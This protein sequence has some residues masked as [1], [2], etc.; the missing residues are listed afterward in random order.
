[1]DRTEILVVAASAVLVALILWFFFGAGERAGDRADA[2]S[3]RDAAPG[4]GPAPPRP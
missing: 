1:M 4:D 3:P 2:T